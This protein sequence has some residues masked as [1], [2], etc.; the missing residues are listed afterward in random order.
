M[1]LLVELFTRYYFKQIISAVANIVSNSIFSSLSLNKNTNFQMPLFLSNSCLICRH[2]GLVTLFQP[3]IIVLVALVSRR[4]IFI[5]GYMG[6]CLLALYGEEFLMR[7]EY[8][9][10]RKYGTVA[11]SPENVS[12]ESVFRK[13]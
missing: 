11:G 12:L 9:I 3:C 2:S 4:K 5:I 6:V 13:I 7:T 1:H 8:P 10:R